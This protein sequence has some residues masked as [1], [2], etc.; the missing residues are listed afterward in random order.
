MRRAA[1]ILAAS[2]LAVLTLAQP[3]A[4]APPP[5]PPDPSCSPG[6][7]SCFDWHTSDVTV[8]W[9]AAPGGVTATGCGPTTISGDTGG[10][11]VSCTWANAEGSRTTTVLVRRDAS[12]P[13]VTASPA[14]GP[15]SNGWYNHP[16]GVG[17]SGSDGTSGIASCS[18]ASYGGPDTSDTNVQ[19][20]C[21]D[22]AGNTGGASYSLK[23]DATAP[24][25]SASPERQPDANGW[26]NKALSVRFSGSDALSGV[27]SCSTAAY[28]GPDTPEASVSGSCVDSAG[29]TG[30]ATLKVQYDATAPTAEAKAARKPDA[31]GWYNRP[32]TVAFHGKD[33]VSG[34]EACAP[35]IR[36][37]GPNRRQASVTGT[38]RD[39]AANTSQPAALVLKY[40]AKPPRLGRVVSEIGARGVALRWSGSKD[41]RTFA[42]LRRPGLR[43]PKP[44]TVYEGRRRSFTDRRVRNGVSYRY[45]VTA[46]DEAGNGAT[47]V[48]LVQPQAVTRSAPAVPVQPVQRRPALRGP[49]TGARL[50]L[51][52]LLSWS[53]VPRATYYNVQLYRDGVKILTAWPR[54]TAFRLSQSWRYGGRKIVLTPGRYRWYVWPGYGKPADSRYGKLIGSR[55][56]VVTGR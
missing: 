56:F 3:A 53:P 45:T 26:Y 27:A 2:A 48:V 41:S 28:N 35:P 19:G 20:S 43:G 24:S 11:A 36:Y 31:N 22:N 51:P 54:V 4:S 40:D 16:V 49:A 32:V 50:S 5:A 13:S 7:A 6:P 1:T 9:A 8:T 23:Y 38:C 34:L 46:Y 14:R 52:P 37:R 17:F 21:T 47:K 44:S 30:T 39:R 33:E 18:S 10:E 55:W 29:N 15:D 12:P 25:V 42:V